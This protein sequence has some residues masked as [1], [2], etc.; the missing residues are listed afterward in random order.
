MS[1]GD[2]VI[3]VCAAALALLLVV[4][5]VFL[6]CWVAVGPS[7][8]FRERWLGQQLRKWFDR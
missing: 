4:A 8:G 7:P 1:G 5:L 3:Q 2:L 6:A